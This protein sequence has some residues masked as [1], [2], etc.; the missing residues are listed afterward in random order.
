MRQFTFG[1]IGAG[2]IARQFCDAVRRIEGA[3]VIAVASKSMERAEA[4]AEREM[5]PTVFENYEEMLKHA[6]PDAVYIAT[7]HN[8]HAD[9]IRLC[10]SYGI[11][12][13]CEKP[14]VLNSADAKELFAL[15]KEKNVLLMEAMWSRYLPHIQ[16]AKE[17]IQSGK[18]GT[19][20]LANCV[21]G[22]YG[23]R[24]PHNRVFSKDLAG[25]ALYDIGV[26]TIELMTYLIGQKLN[27]AQVMT[28]LTSTGVDGSNVISMRF[29][30]CTAALQSTVMASPMQHLTING[31]NGYIF[32][33]NSNVGHEAFLYQNG[34]L[35]EHFEQNYPN[36]F[37]WEI[38]D[39]ISCVKA[40]KLESDTV[41]CADTV[42]CAAIFDLANDK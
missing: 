2:G 17:W 12:V 3:E 28:Q 39:F 13:L 18:I 9:N 11:P 24:N 19:L 21:V 35:S 34:K 20:R 10:L 14:M 40:G 38:E 5:I 23:E 42:E 36:G 8:F 33:P 32:I 6:R 31:E 27:E 4:F 41:P 7:T 1:I 37:V 15:A 22:F 26:Y 25:G 16:K 30:T 29:E